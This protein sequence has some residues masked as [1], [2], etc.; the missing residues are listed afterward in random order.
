MTVDEL[1]PN[2][3][4]LPEKDRADLA[5]FLLN[6][7]PPV[8]Y[9][10]GDEEIEERLAELEADPSIAMGQA[11]FEQATREFLDR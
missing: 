7:L 6:T 2:L 11:E 1:K 10:V 8:E 3:L 9:D 5:S 4:A